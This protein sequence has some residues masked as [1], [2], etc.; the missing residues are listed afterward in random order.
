MSRPAQNQ[1]YQTYSYSLTLVAGC[2][3]IY[4]RVTGVQPNSAGVRI[5]PAGQL[6]GRS[7]EAMREQI[8]A[9]NLSRLH[10]LF[11][12]RAVLSSR[13]YILLARQVASES[14]L[15]TTRPVILNDGTATGRTGQLQ[16]LRKQQQ[17][18]E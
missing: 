13:L 10:D 8:T 18:R 3:H 1:K 7:E 15:E 16:L 6:H 12:N 5:L 4:I 11:T 17:P 14:V 2:E 9:A